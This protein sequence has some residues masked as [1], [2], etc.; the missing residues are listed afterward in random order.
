VIIFY[1]S[2]NNLNCHVISICPGSPGHFLAGGEALDAHVPDDLRPFVIRL[3]QHGAGRQRRPGGPA[4][5]AG[6]EATGARREADDEF[7][8][9]CGTYRWKS[10]YRSRARMSRDVVARRGDGYRSG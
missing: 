8:D 9:E 3:V 1:L 5:P 6:P 10:G 2:T 7:A 4:G